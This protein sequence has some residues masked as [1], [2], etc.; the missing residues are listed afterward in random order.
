MSPKPPR[1]PTWL[2]ELFAPIETAEGVLGDLEEEFAGRLT[3]SEQSAARS[4][5]WR[6]ALRTT[7]HLVWGAVRAA[8]W[9]T[10]AQVLASLVAGLLLYGM[11]NVWVSRLVSNLP[12]YDYQTSVWSWRGA[13]IVRFVALPVALGWSIAA[14]ARGREM[15]ITTLVVGVLIGM[16]LLTLTVNARLLM[17]G[18]GHRLGA[19]WILLYVFEAF[20]V[21]TLFPLGVLVGGMIRRFQRLRGSD[22]VAA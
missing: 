3:R 19:Y 12:I 1:A 16:L 14:F 5:Y 2:V 20:L 15:I 13:A 8:P 6:Q 22:R 10:T 7:V 18:P 17:L 21:Q 9:S 11:M 4:W